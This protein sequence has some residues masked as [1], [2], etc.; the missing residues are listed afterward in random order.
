MDQAAVSSTFGTL[1][2]VCWCIQLLPQIWLNY[3]R[4]SAAGLSPA[5][6]LFWASAGVPLGVYNIVASLPLALQ[7]QPQILSCLSLVTWMQCYYYQRRWSVGRAVA[8]GT[9]VACVLGGLE[10]GLVWAVRVGVG[11]G[12]Q[13]P[14]TLMAVL[15]AVFLALGVLEQYVAIIRHRSA[16]G[17]SFLFCGLDALGDLTSIVAVVYGTRLNVVGLVAYAVELGLWMGVFALGGWFRLRPWVKAWARRRRGSEAR[18][19]ESA[20]HCRHG[21]HDRHDPQPDTEQAGGVTIQDLPSASSVFQTPD[22]AH[23]LRSRHPVAPSQ[24]GGGLPS[25][26]GETSV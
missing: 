7:I 11:R 4:H 23:E 18:Q 20:P 21:H 10:M 8:V 14:L 3:R 25:R 22:S 17:V 9:A 16:E 2:A 24:L 13:A 12:V 6:M 5:F 1:G 15:A 26:E 19:G